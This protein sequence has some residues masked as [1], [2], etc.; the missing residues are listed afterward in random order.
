MPGK[1]FLLRFAFVG[2]IKPGQAPNMSLVAFVTAAVDWRFASVAIRPRAAL[3]MELA[4]LSHMLMNGL[5]F[6]HGLDIGCS[7]V[8][9]VP[10]PIGCLAVDASSTPNAAGSTVCICAR[11]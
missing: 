9:A 1:R 2:V 11:T 5:F 8:E 3:A 10:R 7:F 6:S 4:P